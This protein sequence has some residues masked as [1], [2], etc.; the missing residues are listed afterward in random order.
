MRVVLLVL[1]ACLV[2]AAPA[3]A[4]CTDGAIECNDVIVNPRR[5]D[6]TKPPV[7]TLAGAKA[8]SQRLVR[9]RFGSRSSLFASCTRVDRREVRCPYVRWR[10]DDTHWIV[11]DVLVTNPAGPAGVRVVI[12]RPS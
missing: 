11:G 9:K 2:L 1:L 5:A 12:T 8:R 3:A 4:S 6:P 7:V 10:R